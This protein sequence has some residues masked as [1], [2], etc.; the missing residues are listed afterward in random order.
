MARHE[1]TELERAEMEARRREIYETLY[2]LAKYGA[3]RNVL[4]KVE[5]CDE[6]L[7]DTVS[8]SDESNSLNLDEKTVFTLEGFFWLPPVTSGN[9]FCFHP[10]S[11][12]SPPNP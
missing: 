5:S 6:D 3:R 10:P 2:P 1:L 4:I 12:L 11:F 8:S 9:F 7:G